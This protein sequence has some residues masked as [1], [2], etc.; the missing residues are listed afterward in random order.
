MKYYGEIQPTLSEKEKLYALNRQRNLEGWYDK[1]WEQFD[2]RGSQK[3]ALLAGD[4][5]VAENETC[6]VRY[7]LTPLGDLLLVIVR[8]GET[9]CVT[10][11]RLRGEK[12]VDFYVKQPFEYENEV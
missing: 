11:N 12:K 3:Q 7:Q 4:A 5:V 6:S 10:V 1:L 2:F 8:E 9:K